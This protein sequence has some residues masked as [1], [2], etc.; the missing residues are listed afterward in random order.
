MLW[1]QARRSETRDGEIQNVRFSA[2]SVVPRSR[3]A[4]QHAGVLQGFPGDP[5]QAARYENPRR[6]QIW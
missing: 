2:A 6:V 5:E 3:P 1:K 4:L